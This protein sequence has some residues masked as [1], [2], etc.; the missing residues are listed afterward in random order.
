[1]SPEIEGETPIFL[2]GHMQ[3]YSLAALVTFI[4]ILIIAHFTQ[5]TVH[6]LKEVAASLRSI[7]KTLYTFGKR[8]E[9]I[10]TQEAPPEKLSQIVKC[11]ACEHDIIV[12]LPLRGK[13]YTCPRC[14]AVFEVS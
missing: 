3:F 9:N 10:V 13:D 8:Q 4:C 2:G 6:Y 7:E 14:K 12:E 5:Q 1:L 11:P